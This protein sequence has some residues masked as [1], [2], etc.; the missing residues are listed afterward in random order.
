MSDSM[1]TPF[2]Q[3]SL[4]PPDPTQRVERLDRDSR[5]RERREPEEGGKET[6]RPYHPPP[7]ED[8]VEISEAALRALQEARQ[9]P[10]PSA[11]A[12]G[13]QETLSS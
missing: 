4:E 7:E 5:D 12:P 3:S 6:R 13:A 1:N 2:G 8:R 11:P 9:V 10:P